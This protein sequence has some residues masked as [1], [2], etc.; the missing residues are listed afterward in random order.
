MQGQVA[1]PTRVRGAVAVATDTR[2]GRHTWRA[3]PA[4]ADREYLSEAAQ[5][6]AEVLA[7]AREVAVLEHVCCGALVMAAAGHLVGVGVRVGVRLRL[8]LSVV[9]VRVRVRALVSAQ[10]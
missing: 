10:G 3:A 2:Q 5:Q 6:P 4:R 7:R 9:G 8:R 1:A